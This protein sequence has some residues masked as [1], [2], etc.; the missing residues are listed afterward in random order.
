[1]TRLKLAWPQ[2]KTALF[3]LTAL[4]GLGIS[5][6]LLV[7]YLA[8]TAVACGL[9]SGCDVVRLSEYSWV[10]GI[11]PRPLLGIVFYIGMI[12][13]AMIRISWDSHDKYYLDELILLGTLI[14][15]FESAWLFYVQAEIIGAFCL[16]CLG[17]GV[18]TVA[19]FLLALT[20]FPRLTKHP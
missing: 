2:W 13:L 3:L 4:V 15:V 14:G 7:N 16:W 1:M 8:G 6:Y 5:S 11:I 12:V 19:M 17:S 18:A 9:G 10:W 20:P